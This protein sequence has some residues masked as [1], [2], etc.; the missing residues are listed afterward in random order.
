MDTKEMQAII[1][2]VASTG[3]SYGIA[4]DAY[5]IR[6]DKLIDE[7]ERW[8]DDHDS[9]SI[10]IDPDLVYWWGDIVCVADADELAECY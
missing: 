2:K 6:G 5:I 1:D 8:D 9:N 7:Q 3:Q 10:G 4:A